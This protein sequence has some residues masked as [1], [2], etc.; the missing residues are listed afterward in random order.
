[1]SD[2][3]P[4][5]EI[6]CDESGSEGEKLVGG[7][8]DVFAHASVHLGTESAAAC[9]R[10]IRDRIRSPATEYKAGHLLRGKHRAVLIWLLGE[11]G[12]VLRNAHV[13]LV[14]KTFLI[15]IKVADLITV[16]GVYAASI[17]LY[18]GPEATV[19]AGTLNRD[20]PRVF[21]LARWQ[22]FLQAFN[23]LMRTR[24]RWGPGISV[25]Q[26]FSMVDAMRRDAAA[27]Q[28]GE[29][30]GLLYRARPLVE[31][32]R[33]HVLDDPA[34]VP[35]M[36]PLV[37]AIVQAVAFWGRDGRPVSIIHDHQSMLT[38][39]RIAQLKRALGQ[40][41]PRVIR[42]SPGGRP[43]ALRLVD[44][45]LVES[46][47]DSRVQVADFLAGVA[48]KIASDELNGRPDDELTTLLRPYLDP[49]SIWDPARASRPTP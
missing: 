14:D 43:A 49:F 10:E 7:V 30:I 8:T 17:G 42:R 25:E 1:M 12:P 38:A 36:D 29:L 40:P 5:I 4:T 33:A 46:L 23:D 37:P 13:H 20:G 34:M 28:V 47:S 3:R 41:Q 11:A 39:E 19:L 35:T 26:F 21:G 48:R 32:I 44:L 45:R 9:V 2:P 15:L 6:A 16:D 31:A 18:P 24:N 22:A 27:G